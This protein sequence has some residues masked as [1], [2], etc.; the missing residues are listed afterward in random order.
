MTGWVSGW[1]LLL[2]CSNIWV[3]GW[4]F[5]GW[6]TGLPLLLLC[7]SDSWVGRWLSRWMGDWVGGWVIEWVEG[8]LGGHYSYYAAL[9]VGRMGDWAGGR[10]TGWPLLPLWYPDSWLNLLS[11]LRCSYRNSLIEQKMQMLLWW[12]R[13][14]GDHTTVDQLMK[15]LVKLQQADLAEGVA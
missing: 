1:S 12:Q 13:K 10:V 7:C 11:F 2:C 6:V 4:L 5:S 3:D 15:H 9:I 14:K 8:W